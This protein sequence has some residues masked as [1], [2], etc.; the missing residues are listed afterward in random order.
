MID[1]EG[2]GPLA[3]THKHKMLSSLLLLFPNF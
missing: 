3:Q 1:Q 2:K